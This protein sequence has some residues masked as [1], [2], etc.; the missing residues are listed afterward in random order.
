MS[1]GERGGGKDV[2]R[3][4]QED[5]QNLEVDWAAEQFK[6]TKGDPVSK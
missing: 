3:L 1:K 2:C 4:R 6:A 5:D